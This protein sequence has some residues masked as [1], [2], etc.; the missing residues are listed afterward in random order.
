[1]EL[2]KDQINFYKEKGFIIVQSLFKEWEIENLVQATKKFEDL[3]SLP[4]IICEKNNEVRSV[5][6]P[7]KYSDQFDSIF[8]E[9]RLVSTAETLIGDQV[10]LYQFKLNNKK[11][12]K[13]DCWEW[14]QDFPYWYY[15]DGV[16]QPN[17]ISV[18]ILLQDTDIFQGPLL[19]IPGSHK[20]GIV[21]M[22][23]KEHLQGEK[24]I[25]LQNSL[26]ADLKFTIKK[27][28]IHSYFENEKPSVFQG[29]KGS[30]LF[31]H[32]NLFHASN[33]NLSPYDRNT[34]I[35]TY[36]SVKNVPEFKADSRPD[37][38]CSRDIAPLVFQNN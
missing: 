30:C 5:F 22:A 4:N 24:K 27:E 28:L 7:H 13:G 12:L 33:A 32:P 9:Q 36:N 10:Y 15:D 3:G 18:M 38:L 16:K 31:F 26:N 21:E 20:N 35:I 8:R 25:T 19:V 11:A 34:A 17:M 37:Y 23:F 14:H 29:K 2:K 6:A 1:M